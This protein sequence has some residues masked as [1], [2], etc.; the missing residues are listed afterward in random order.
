MLVGTVVFLLGIVRV[1]GRGIC[2]RRVVYLAVVGWRWWVG[3][4]VLVG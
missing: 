2:F 1:A 3:T 4:V